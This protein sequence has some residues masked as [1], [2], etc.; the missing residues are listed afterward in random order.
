MT[1]YY[2]WSPIDDQPGTL[3][4]LVSREPGVFG[5]TCVLKLFRRRF[6][7]DFMGRWTPWLGTPFTGGLNLTN[8]IVLKFEVFPK[9]EAFIFRPLGR[10]SSWLYQSGK[11][12]EIRD[13]N[14]TVNLDSWL[15]LFGRAVMGP[16]SASLVFENWG[17][18]H[19]A[20]YMT[21][22]RTIRNTTLVI[23]ARMYAREWE[24][25]RERENKCR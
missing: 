3:F 23:A 20:K 10:S 19:A 5:F 7:F 25:E 4:G 15:L 8:V 12:N 2:K 18:C 1:F 22:N 9:F 13:D 11:P 17:V 14:L 16:Y 24:Q 6:T 21:R